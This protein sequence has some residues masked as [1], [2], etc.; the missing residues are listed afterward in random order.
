MGLSSPKLVLSFL[1]LFQSQGKAKSFG[2]GVDIDN[3]GVINSIR[4]QLEISGDLFSYTRSM[5]TDYKGVKIE[6]IWKAQED[7]RAGN[8]RYFYSV[9]SNQLDP[10]VITS[11]QPFVISENGSWWGDVPLEVRN[12]SCAY[13]YPQE[14]GGQ[15]LYSVDIQTEFQMKVSTK[16]TS[17]PWLGGGTERVA[18][19][20]HN[21][22]PERW[23]CDAIMGFPSRSNT[24]PGEVPVN[25]VGFIQ[26]KSYKFNGNWINLSSGYGAA[27]GFGN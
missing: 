24:F 22:T 12:F 4:G 16:Y 5:T 15:R 17:T 11:T 9:K 18:L 10:S 6:Q 8:W 26:V 27:Y 13:G 21:W 25:G 3:V 14:G 20:L 23:N 7:R 19:Y 1:I 2:G